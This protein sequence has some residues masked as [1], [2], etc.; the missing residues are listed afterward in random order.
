MKTS[1]KRTFAQRWSFP[2]TNRSLVRK[3]Q[4]SIKINDDKKL[5]EGN[6]KVICRPRYMAFLNNITLIR[7]VLFP[8]NANKTNKQKRNSVLFNRTFLQVPK[9]IKEIHNHYIFG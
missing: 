9:M 5:K 8:Q 6:D 7:G 4:K 1:Y 3:E 2:R